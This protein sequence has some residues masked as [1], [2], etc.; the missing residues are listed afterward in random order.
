MYVPMATTKSLYKLN[1]ITGSGNSRKNCFNKPATTLMSPHSS[2]STF[3]GSIETVFFLVDTL[4]TH[5][6]IESNTGTS[7]KC[8]A[9]FIDA[10][11]RS[12]YPVDAYL[13]QPTLFN[14]VNAFLH[15]DWHI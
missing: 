13:A 7:I 4:L 14:L 12:R 10:R 6:K 5:E 11:D 2:K 3:S 8:L 1:G 9:K 15:N